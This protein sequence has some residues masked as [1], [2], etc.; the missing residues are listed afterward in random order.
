MGNIR[1]DVVYA[2]GMA[3]PNVR[4]GRRQTAAGNAVTSKE[5]KVKCVVPA[6]TPGLYSVRGRARDQALAS[7]VPTR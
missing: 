7:G 5:R 6:K 3:I 2:F 1:T 4:T